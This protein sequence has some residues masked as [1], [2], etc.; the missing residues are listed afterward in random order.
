MEYDG[1]FT[2]I[3]DDVAEGF[4][5]SHLKTLISNLGYTNLSK[6][7]YLD[8]RKSMLDG[9]RYLG[10]DDATFDPFINLLVEYEKVGKARKIDKDYEEELRQLKRVAENKRKQPAEEVDSEY[11]DSTDLDSP[12][13]AS[14]E[15][16][17]GYI[18][19]VPTKIKRSSTFKK[20]KQGTTPQETKF[21]IGQEFDN[22]QHLKKAITDY[23]I[24]MGEM[25]ISL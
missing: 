6:L 20:Y 15:E 19:P 18:V 9:I 12:D 7:H 3:F 4:N 25:C 2:N 23:C 10:Y 17:C 8:P 1:G 21:Y 14:D 5:A 11:E 24:F 16:D 13:D 22:A